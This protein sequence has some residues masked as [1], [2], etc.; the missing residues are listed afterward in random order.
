MQNL[1]SKTEIS[2][3]EQQAIDFATKYGVRLTIGT[4]VYST[5]FDDDTTRRYVF[6]CKLQ[7][8]GKSYSFKFGQSISKDNEQPTMYDILA[9][10]EKYESYSFEDFCANYGYNED[11]RKAEKTYKAV[12]KEYAAVERLFG[13]IMEELQEIQ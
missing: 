5:H 12:C 6:P 3:Y 8:N 9:C 11:S 10:L 1:Q 2:S 13:D 7:R 4:P